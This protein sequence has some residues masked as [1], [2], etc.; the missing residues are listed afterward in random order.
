MI[1]HPATYSAPV[2][3]CFAKHIP[4]GA[5]VLDPFAGTGKIHN[6]SEGCDT[7][8]VG[9]E[10]EPEWAQMREGTIVG[11]ARHLPFADGTFT[12]IATSPVYGNRMS[13]HHDAKDKCKKCDGAGC[14]SCVG[15]GLSMR[16]TYK[17]Q[18]G[19]DLSPGSSAV[20][21]WGPDYR[22]FH[23]LAWAEAVRVLC[24]GGMFLL[25]V[26]DHIRKGS[27]VPVT[28]WH[29][30]VLEGLLKL[31][32]DAKIPIVTKRMRVGANFDK[33]VACEY[34]CKFYKDAG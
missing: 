18:L 14:K 25:N 28:E 8:T 16:K 29:C 3:D 23:I 21:Q 30:A 33:R 15:T 5:Y 19:R 6:L 34:V 17:H 27:V 26:S 2:L 7:V 9:I 31:R 10:L 22:A 4:N 32:L 24:D 20:L 11:D 13:D 12:V 1:G